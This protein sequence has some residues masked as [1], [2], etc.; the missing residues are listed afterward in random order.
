MTYARIAINYLQL[1]QKLKIRKDAC[2]RTISPFSAEIGILC[3]AIFVKKQLIAVDIALK[4][5][6]LLARRV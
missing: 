3:C 4:R 1:L 5:G 6:S 2:F